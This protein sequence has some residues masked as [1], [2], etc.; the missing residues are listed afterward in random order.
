MAERPPTSP[1]ASPASQPHDE[2][3][4]RGVAAPENVVTGHGGVWRAR[5]PI[6][7]V[8]P[9]SGARADEC[10]HARE[11]HAAG[12][13]DRSGGAGER[14]ADA[15]ER[16]HGREGPRPSSLGDG[17]APSEYGFLDCGVQA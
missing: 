2:A 13:G 7:G 3:R 15:A 14:A 17:E 6:A 12:A 10:L 9:G 8:P 16:E 4:G 5:I 1:A 11:L